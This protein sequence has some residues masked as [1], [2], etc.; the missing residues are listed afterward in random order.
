MFPRTGAEVGGLSDSSGLGLS[1]PS[2]C[3]V[4]KYVQMEGPWRWGSPESRE[5]G[6][7]GGIHSDKNV[8]AWKKVT[9]HGFGLLFLSHPAILKLP[10]ENKF[11]IKS[12]GPRKK[13][14]N[15]LVSFAFTMMFIVSFLSNFLLFSPQLAKAK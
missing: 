13:Q 3:Y 11:L 10:S 15:F 14:Y 8:G 9:I 2:K 7:N 4:R 1:I 12:S 6:K 5:T